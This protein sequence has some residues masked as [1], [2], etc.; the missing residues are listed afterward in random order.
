MID[1]FEKMNT[2]SIQ[3]IKYVSQGLEALTS[4]ADQTP[5]KAQVSPASVNFC[6]LRRLGEGNWKQ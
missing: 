1:R 2:T 4:E 5:Q 3:D 6:L